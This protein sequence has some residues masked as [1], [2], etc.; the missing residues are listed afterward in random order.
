M[1]DARSGNANGRTQGGSNAEIVIADA[2]VKGLEGIDYNLALEAMLKD[3]TVD[4]GGTHEAEGRGGLREYLELGYVP[5]GIPRAGN[6]T[7]EYSYCD[8][9][10]Y[11]VA[12]GLGNDALAEKYLK[13]SA[14]WKNL[15]RSDYEHDGTKGF[16]MPRDQDGNWLDYIPFGHSQKR[17]P[18][19]KYT[20]VTF[21]GPGIHPGGA[22]S[23]MR[24]PP[25]NIL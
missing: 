11:L 10:I 4:P 25:G 7:V 1:P 16:I 6:R 15:W 8:Y 5:Y 12:K 18:M 9:A 19:F 20:P 14:N 2:F 21:E 3:A 23:S 17:R 22:C 13:Q 24:R